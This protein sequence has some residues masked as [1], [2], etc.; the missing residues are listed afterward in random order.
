MEHSISNDYLQASVLSKGTEISSIKSLKTGKEYM[1]N[2]DPSIWGSHAPVLFPAIGSFKNNECKINGSVYNIPKHGFIRHNKSMILKSCTNHELNF[3]LDYSEDSLQIF[4]YKFRFNI[5]FKLV[6]NRLII[7][8]KVENLDSKKMPF[9]L[10]AHPAFNCPLNEGE[11]YSD[12]YLEFEKEENASRTLLSS[13]GLITD[14]LN[15]VLENSK[16]LN[17]KSDLFDED[18]LI[19]K[20]LKSKKVSLKSRKSNQ[21]LT[22]VYPDF[23]YL[24]IWAKPNAPF[25][26][27]E[28][29]L[30]IADHENTDGNYLKK[31]GLITLPKGEIF[32]AQYT[33]E[34]KE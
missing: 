6:E 18:A 27:V 29:W 5:S 34:I 19:F 33:I 1:W 10:G 11:E 25:V 22:V 31:D 14:Q 8:H 2:A 20:N 17:L 15:P 26:C 23:S 13:E 4:P 9:S 12:Y 28:P 30:G 7:S 32:K 3:Q 24:G 16:V 21:V